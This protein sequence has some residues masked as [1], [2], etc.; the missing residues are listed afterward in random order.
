MKILQLQYFNIY[1]K[2]QIK[3]LKY[4]SETSSQIWGNPWIRECSK[5]KKFMGQDLKEM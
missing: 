2:F 1:N 4:L 5:Q 3:H